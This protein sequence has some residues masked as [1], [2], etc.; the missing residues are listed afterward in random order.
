[1]KLTTLII[2]IS[3]LQVSASSFA[4]KITLSQ[5]NAS[6]PEVF[7]QIKAQSGYDFIFN[8][9]TVKGAGKISIHVKNAGLTETLKQLFAGQPL[10][11]TIENNSVIVTK[12]EVTTTA[13]IMVET[14]VNG[15]VLDD[16]GLPIPGVTVTVKNSPVQTVTNNNGEYTIK[17]EPDGVLMFS[18]IGYQTQEVQVANKKVIDVVLA[19][20]L[21]KLDEVVVVAYGTQQRKT[22]TGAISTVQSEDLTAAPLAGVTNALA[23]RLPGLVS[24][25]LSGQPGSDAATLSIRGFGNALVIVDGVESNMNNIDANQIE[26]VSILK[27]ASASIYGARAGNGVILVTTKRGG[28]KKPIISLASNYTLQ[29]VTNMPHPVNAGQYAELRR[30]AWLQSG[31]PEATAPYTQEQINKYYDGTDPN[32]PNTDWYDVL[33]R[34]WAPQVQTNLSVRG[35]SEKIKFYGFLGYTDQESIWRKNGGDYNR[36]NLQSNIDAKITDN[37]SLQFDLST[38]IEDMNYPLRPQSSNGAAWQD[39]WNTLPIY[40][41][42]F[43]DPTKIPFANG[44]GTGGAHIT[45]NSDISGYNKTSKQNLKGTIALNYNI[46][47]VKGLS[48]RALFNYLQDYITEKAFTK[49]VS[50]YYYDYTSGI[51]SLA[52]SM[53]SKASLSI[54]DTKSRIL[55]TQLSLNYDR[56]IRDDHHISALA[57]YEEITSRSDFLTGARTNFLTPAIDQLFGGSTVNQFANGLATEGGRKSYIGRLKYDYKS[58]YLFEATLRADASARFAPEKRWGYFP[59]VSAG[60][61]LSREKF[62]ANTSSYLDE[63]KLRASYG[64][65]GNDGIGNFQ[66]LS[67]YQYGGTYLFGNNA[68]QGIASTWLANPN[69]T[70]ERIKI[71]NVGLDASFWNGLLSG[72]FEVFYRERNGILFTRGNTLP[73][74]FGALLPTENINSTNDRGFEVKLGTAGKKNDFSWNISANASWSRS[75]WN[76]Y[77][78]PEYT[79]PDQIRISKR[80][81]RWTDDTYGY[82]SDGL[83]TSMDQIAALPFDQDGQKNASLRPGDIRFIDL[84]G[85]GRL[86][87]RDQKN[88]GMGSIPHWMVGLNAAF[89]YKN[90]DL[91]T[92]WQ[93][94]FGH[95]TYLTLQRGLVPIETQFNSRWTEANNNPNALVPRSGGA[96][97][98]SFA[99]D[100]YYKNAG[101]LR[102]KSLTVGYSLPASV[103]QKVN[104]QQL[105]IYFAGTNL[106]TFDRLKDYG[107]DP[108]APA[109]SLGLYYPQQRTLSLGLNVSL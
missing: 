42:E 37:L 39:F 73:S 41:S 77:E 83:F 106:L 76:H 43:P 88:V 92:L 64:K 86:D 17:T 96:A 63:L 46:A 31:Q 52:G 5:T 40:P 54:G 89:K 10:N 21:G 101:Y 3:M 61:V 81:G 47:K 9:T 60:W 91:A 109:G 71:S 82:I 58:K 38:V 59:G 48:A 8:A 107:V 30:E 55:T 95:Y 22:L 1:M 28:G 34:P 87:W 16:K 74:T 12:K 24:Q 7:S 68:S 90:F 80:S 6:L 56:I 105:R 62:L 27:D 67:G 36:Y 18:Y 23:G 53:G 13:P 102:L 2:V 44:G 93:G 103:L 79:D 35:G 25:Q 94:A 32:F 33:I 49:P 85:D 97:S 100:F 108:E 98:N 19:L 70:W 78:E 75:K 51:Y 57:L 29:G 69:L 65:S 66:F 99:S 14:T 11:Y 4:Q 72:Q 26:S 104:V 45:T 15:R 84:N 50:F 20:N